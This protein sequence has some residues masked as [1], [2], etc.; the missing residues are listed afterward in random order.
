MLKFFRHI[1]QKMLSENKFSK[2]LLYAIGEIV[3]VVIGILIALQINNWNEQRKKDE[4]LK[5]YRKNLVAELKTDL[6]VLDSLNRQREAHEKKVNDYINYYNQENILIDTL[7]QKKENVSYSLD[8]FNKSSFTLDEL[9]ATGNI[10]LFSDSEKEAIAKL[11]NTHEIFQYY[12]RKTLDATVDIIQEYV[13]ATDNFYENKITPKQHHSV[14][15][16]QHNLDSRQYLLLNNQFYNVIVLY[17]FQKNMVYPA[18]RKDTEALMNILEN[19]LDGNY[20]SI[21]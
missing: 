13:M 16:W 7:I 1:R 11:K 21:K 14:K 12:E 2:Y 8:S 20:K 15:D 17:K 10:S 9:G 6:K 5:Q 3:L 18:I 19:K 4:Q